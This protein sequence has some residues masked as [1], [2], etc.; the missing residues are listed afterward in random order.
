M[1]GPDERALMFLGLATRAGKT[2]SGDEACR[3]ALQK[4][5]VRLVVVADDASP[6]TKERFRRL[7]GTFGTRYRIHGTREGLGI[8]A[9]RPD[10]AIVGVTDEGFAARLAELMDEAAGPAAGPGG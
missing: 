8:F 10:R 9:G 1:P 6:G 7:A 4:G 2:V 3:A 5:L